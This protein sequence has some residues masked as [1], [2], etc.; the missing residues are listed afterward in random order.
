METITID[1][2]DEHAFRHSVEDM[3]RLGDVDAAVADLR[4]LVTP[5]AGTIL[6][7]RFAEVSAAD[8]EITGWDRIG[9]RLNHHHR[10]G[11]PITA[12]GVV[13]AD[14]RVLGGPGPQHGRLAPFIKTYYFSDDAYPFTNAAR[15]DLLDGYSREGF[16][17][18]GDYQATDA[19]IGI[20]GIDD[21]HGALIELEDRL[22]DSARPPEEHLRAGTVGA[23]YLAALIHQALRDT[24]R[25]Q[26]MPRPLC[27]LAACD[28]IYPFFDAPVAGWDE[29]APAPAPTPEL[30]AAGAAAWAD[31]T[32]EA[33]AEE[34]GESSLLSL[35][36][37]KA[38]KQ[39]AL[40]IGE[41]DALAAARYTEEASAQ[42]LVVADESTLRGLFHGRPAA[43]PEEL[44]AF[45]AEAPEPSETFADFADHEI[46]L[47][48][49]A[50]G[51]PAEPAL[52]E[53]PVAAYYAEARAEFRR[54]EEAHAFPTGRALRQRLQAVEPE[55]EPLRTRLLAPLVAFLA[56]LRRHA[57]RR[58][59][60]LRIGLRRRL[61][62]L[63]LRRRMEAMRQAM[64]QVPARLA[65]R[66]TR[67]SP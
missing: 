5:F 18:Q 6:P 13:L 57:L 10:S 19:T 34:W 47:V 66:W 20:K 24:I 42:R 49:E 22:L 33:A 59:R 16:G 36:V 2:V 17:W 43:T 23:C 3:L 40:A 67:P 8:L 46:P 29:A 15:E 45:A 28:G 30:A 64:A 12:I 61:A 31:E 27:V 51:S 41:E 48:D 60:R 53:D 4:T 50:I 39:L 25:R 55:T 63:D 37:R 65:R 9:Q 58:L 44:A 14:A 32:E 54:A 62:R 38:T 26:G 52:P 35:T 11:F 56:L 21:L 1:G 7:R